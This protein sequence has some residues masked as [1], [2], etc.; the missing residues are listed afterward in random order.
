METLEQDLQYLRLAAGSLEDFLLSDNTYWPLPELA[1]SRETY[2]VS[3]LSLGGLLSVLARISART[4]THAQ[5]EEFEGLRAKVEQAKNRWR[6]HWMQKAEKEFPQRL[7]LWQNFL[8]DLNP[9]SP[10]AQ[11]EYRNEVRWRVML[12]LLQ[13]EADQLPPDAEARLASLDSRLR[14]LW[15]QDGFVWDDELAK[16]FPP[17]GFWFLYG[18]LA[19]TAADR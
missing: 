4:M 11:N 8:G 18:Q 10:S 7:T 3:R 17:D 19:G 13:G 1:G 2:A 16:A 14:A 9:R 15:R 12:E 6:S 5:R